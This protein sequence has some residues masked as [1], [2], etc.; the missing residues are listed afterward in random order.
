[1]AKNSDRIPNL[2]SW[3]YYLI[4]GI[5]FLIGLILML[6]AENHQTENHWIHFIGE[7]GAFVAAA[8][9]SHFI[10]AKLIRKDEEILLVEKL[11]QVQY[12]LESGIISS[13]EKLPVYDFEYDV[14]V[15][16]H[17]IWILQTWIGNF[18]PVENAIR[19]ALEKNMEVEILILNPKSNYAKARGQ[20]LGVVEDTDYVPREINSNLAKFF[21]LYSESNH[22][23]NF[24]I[25]LFDGN[26]TFSIYAVDDIIYLGFFWRKRNCTESPHLKLKLKGNSFYFSHFAK[27]HY[28]IIW[29]EATKVDFNDPEWRKKL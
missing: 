17:K 24:E 14:M 23:N 20:E 9:A 1:M 28:D 15:G 3:K 27:M 26:S 22:P 13:H 11:K 19:I 18:I 5:V 8:I 6:I 21:Q 2:F 29:K 4:V 7:I 16:K 10:Y 12:E 25:R